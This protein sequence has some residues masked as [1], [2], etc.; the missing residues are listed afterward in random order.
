MCSVLDGRDK[1]LLQWITDSQISALIADNYGV[2]AVPAKPGP[3]NAE[4]PSLPIHN[5]CL[6]KLG[7]NLGEIWWLKDLALWLRDNKRSRF[8]LTAPPLAPARR[9]RLA[10]DAGGDCLDLGMAL[11]VP[12]AR[13]Q[14]LKTESRSRCSTSAARAASIRCGA[15]SS[16][17][18][19]ALGH[20]RQRGRVPAP[21]RASSAIPTSTTSRLSPATAASKPIELSARPVSA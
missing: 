7:L 21:G 19:R 15:S 1:R 13:R 20:R 8:L 3:D 5:H 17:S 12:G 16:H 18:L 4:H 10:G 6:F 11:V 9:R 14:G 2:E